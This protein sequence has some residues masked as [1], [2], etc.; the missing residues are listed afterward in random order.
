ML[1]FVDDRTYYNEHA[2]AYFKKTSGLDSSTF[3]LPFVSRLKKGDSVLDLGCGSGRDLLWLKNRGMRPM[4]FERSPILAQMARDYSDC[5]VIEGDFLS[6]DFASFRVQALLFSASLVHLPQPQVESA[7]DNALYALDGK[8]VVYVSLKMGEGTSYDT[9]TRRFF[10]WGE[11]GLRMLFSRLGLDV[12]DF[13]KTPSVR[14]TN[15]TWLSFTLYFDKDKP[16][17]RYPD[18]LIHQT[19]FPAF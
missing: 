14:G 11:E 15:E 2:H 7:L 13:R 16:L 4:G 8:G 1:Q 19:G 10:L 9:E 17:Y 6:Y 12:L 3:L 5:P 18:R